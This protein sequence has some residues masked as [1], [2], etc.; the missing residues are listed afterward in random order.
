VKV[1]NFDKSPQEQTL[2]Q[3]PCFAEQE[4]TSP[5]RNKFTEQLEQGWSMHGMHKYASLKKANS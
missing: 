4:K 1:G 5:A 2:K 3:S